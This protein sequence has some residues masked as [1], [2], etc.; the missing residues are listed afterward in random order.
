[1]A[2]APMAGWL[3]AWRIVGVVLL[4]PC[5]VW[6]GLGVETLCSEDGDVLLPFMA[7]AGGFGVA[8]G[9]AGEEGW[10]AAANETDVVEWMTSVRRRIHEHPELAFQEHETS[11]L[12][13]DELDR[14]GV[15]YRFPVAGTG[16][17][18]TIVGGAGSGS[19]V[20]LRADMDALPIQVRLSSIS[21]GK[22]TSIPS[23]E[24]IGRVHL[25]VYNFGLFVV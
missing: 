18:A 21:E 10:L 2:R 24:F 5:T 25:E 8:R 19:T 7:G 17:V 20:A 6:A 16:V 3:C 15:Q 22:L 23:S 11:R 9:R 14:L 13:R 1:M 4:A 12:I